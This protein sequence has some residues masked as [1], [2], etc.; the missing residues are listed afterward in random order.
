MNKQDFRTEL[1]N[2]GHRLGGIAKVNLAIEVAVSDKQIDSSEYNEAIALVTELLMDCNRRIC[3]LVDEA[4]Q[5][6]GI[7]PGVAL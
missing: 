3:G 6:L 7:E 5:V 4:G 2:I 1:E